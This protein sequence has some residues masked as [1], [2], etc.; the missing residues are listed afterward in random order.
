MSVREPDAKMKAAFQK[1]GAQMAQEW[2]KQA[3]ADG[4]EILKRYRGKWRLRRFLDRLYLA[5]GVLAAACLASI[6]VLMLAQAMGRGAGILI[7]GADDI[8]AW[9]TA[10]CAFLA[11]GYTF[12]HGEL[13]RVGLWLHK[14]EPRGRRIAELAA[15]GVTALFGAYM[16]WAISR[17]VYE[18]WT[19]KEVAQGLIPIP[20]WIP[21]MSLVLGAAIFFV[22]VIDELARVARGEKPEYQRAEEARLAAGDYS[23]TV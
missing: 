23:E 6:A 4:Q 22:A 21:Q 13:V 11:L 7:R 19:F 9:L 8:V 1:I 10:A 14:L 3:G 17:F 12:R 2:E 15:L 16:L 5:S 18:S 20:I